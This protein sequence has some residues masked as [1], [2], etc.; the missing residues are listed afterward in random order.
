MVIPLDGSN[1]KSTTK[2]TDMN[3]ELCT[4][5]K[6]L[7]FRA[8]SP[9]QCSL[10][11][12]AIQK[13]SKLKV[14]DIYRFLYTLGT[15]GMTKVVAAKHLTT[16]EDSAI[17]IIDKRLCDKKMLKTEIQILKKLDS[18]FIVRLYDLIETK[19]YLV[20]LD[21]FCLLCHCTFCIF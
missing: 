3:F 4:Q 1:V 10:W 13:A 16:G 5:H 14:K 20:R 17:K 7:Y 2:S 8:A 6:R 19:K 9:A 11:T 15:S 12:E 21:F 18:P